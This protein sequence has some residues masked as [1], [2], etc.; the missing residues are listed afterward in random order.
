MTN[1]VIE[2]HRC[3]SPALQKRQIRRNRYEML[4]FLLEAF[5]TI[6]IMVSFL[7]CAIVFL[8]IV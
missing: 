8:C 3:P 1:N 6:G 2:L 4:S 5:V 7:L